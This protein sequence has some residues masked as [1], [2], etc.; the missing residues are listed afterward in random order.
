MSIERW[1]SECRAVAREIAGSLA[2]PLADS[3]LTAQHPLVSAKFE[4]MRVEHEL[5]AN[6]R[7]LR[8]TLDRRPW[9]DK[10]ASALIHWTGVLADKILAYFESQARIIDKSMWLHLLQTRVDGQPM[11]TSDMGESDIMDVA[12]RRTNLLKTET[13]LTEHLKKLEKEK[14]RLHKQ[15]HQLDARRANFWASHSMAAS[16]GQNFD[17][18][19]SNPVLQSLTRYVS[20]IT[21]PFR[22]PTVLKEKASTT[23]AA[24]DYRTDAIMSRLQAMVNDITRDPNSLSSEKFQNYMNHAL[25]EISSME[26]QLSDL[27]QEIDLLPAGKPLAPKVIRR[28]IWRR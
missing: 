14:E 19:R 28:N 13:F 5:K 8:S 25:G 26:R 10:R 21:A 12:I 7:S 6:I 4:A 16:F 3:A 2:A 15:Y 20:R 22:L 1:D 17:Q 24:I 9:M 27:I 23:K 11:N 18:S